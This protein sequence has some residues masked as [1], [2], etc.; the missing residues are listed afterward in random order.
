MVNWSISIK[1]CI[2][3]CTREAL[4]ESD[5][6]DVEHFVH[7]SDSSFNERGAVLKEEASAQLK[8]A[9]RMRKLAKILP[10][11]SIMLSHPGLFH[12]QNHSS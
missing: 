9:H 1:M 11:G 2:E 10:T 8:Y 6:E 7:T 4:T 3:P 5:I 12:L